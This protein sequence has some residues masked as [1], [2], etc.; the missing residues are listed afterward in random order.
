LFVDIDEAEEGAQGD[1]I[2]GPVLL[3]DYEHVMNLVL[4]KLLD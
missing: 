4:D 1:H 3:V 2:V